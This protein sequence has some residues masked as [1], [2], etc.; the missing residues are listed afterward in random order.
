MSSAKG[1]SLRP[2]QSA[3][4]EW[5]CIAEASLNKNNL[6]LQ[7][8]VLA[9]I[10]IRSGLLQGWI[11]TSISKPRS[12][13]AMGEKK[14]TWSQSICSALLLDFIICLYPFTLLPLS[15]CYLSSSYFF[16]FSFP[17]LCVPSFHF[18]F[19]FP[20]SSKVYLSCWSCTAHSACSILQFPFLS[21]VSLFSGLLFTFTD[22]LS[23]SRFFLKCW[24]L[25]RGWVSYFC[26]VQVA[27]FQ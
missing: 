6:Y 26:V 17:S 11:H 27:A 15:L 5:V 24:N 2:S 16:P 3:E 4:E 8:T 25:P 19:S 9:D 13:G 18:L 1:E 21:S 12:L 7:L 20:P 14:I 22:A 23:F 10:S